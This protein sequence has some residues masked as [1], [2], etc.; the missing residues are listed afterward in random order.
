MKKRKNLSGK[1][2]VKDI[3]NYT[4]EVLSVIREVRLY[5]CEDCMAID[6]KSPFSSHCRS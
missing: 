6:E 1:K 3:I 5:D 2:R 4:N